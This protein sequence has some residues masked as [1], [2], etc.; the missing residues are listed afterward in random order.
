[1]TID[2]APDLSVELPRGDLLIGGSWRPDPSGGRAE[3]INPA[4]GERLTSVAMAG[5]AEVDEAISAAAEASPAWLAWPPARR[6]DVLLELARLIDEHDN[7]LGVLRSLETG[8]PFK[9]K[10]GASLAAEYVRYYAGWVDKLEG[11]TVP[12]SAGPALDYTLPEPYGVVAVLTPWNGGMVS[13][14]MKVAP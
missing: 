14:A 8:A 10:R 2:V 12:T 9:R 1:M 6:R 4:T 11:A 13:P 5:P 3:Q 7:S